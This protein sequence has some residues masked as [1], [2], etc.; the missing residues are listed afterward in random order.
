VQFAGFATYQTS[1]MQFRDRPPTFDGRRLIA[2]V[3]EP[4]IHEPPFRA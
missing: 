4:M 3:F 1:R 2:A